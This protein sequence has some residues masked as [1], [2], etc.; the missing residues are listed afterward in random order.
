[1]FCIC[2]LFLVI[3][4]LF[5]DTINSLIGIAIA[6]SGVPVYFVG[7]YLPESQRPALIRNV[8]GELLCP[9]LMACVDMCVC[10]QM[11]AEVGVVVNGFPY[12]S[13]VLETMRPGCST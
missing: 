3:V 8:L 2:S 5:G 4:P 7:V 13:D 6:L 10:V 12:T 1:M 9:L 11:C